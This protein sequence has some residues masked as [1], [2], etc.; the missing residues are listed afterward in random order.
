[1]VW[2]S[3]VHEPTFASFLSFALSTISGDFDMSVKGGPCVVVTTLEGLNLTYST[4]F[5]FA[6]F[7]ISRCLTEEGVCT[8]VACFG[9]GRQGK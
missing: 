1:M 7:G 5:S 8:L 2:Q 4:S 3:R 6:V 9:K